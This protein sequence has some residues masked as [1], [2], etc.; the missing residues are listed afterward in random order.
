MDAYSL[1]YMYS[2]TAEYWHIFWLIT[3]WCVTSSYGNEFLKK[4]NNPAKTL[5]KRDVF[6]QATAVKSYGDCGVLKAF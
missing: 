5:Q 3:H 1:Q 4:N 6:L 2:L